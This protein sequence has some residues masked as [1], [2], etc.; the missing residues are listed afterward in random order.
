MQVA[1]RYENPDSFIEDGDIYSINN[2]HSDLSDFEISKEQEQFSLYFN[3]I[4]Y[5]DELATLLDHTI[6]QNWVYNNES[7]N[8]EKSDLEHDLILYY[9]DHSLSNRF[10]YNYDLDKIIKS[11]VSYNYDDKKKYVKLYYTFNKDTT[12]LDNTEYFTYDIGYAFNKKYSINHRQEFDLSNDTNQKR[13]YIF[14]I[15]E[16]CW[17]VSFKY[18]NSIIATNTT[19]GN[20]KRENKFY[21]ELNLKELLNFTQKY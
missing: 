2:F 6:F 11:T 21:V 20:S 8:Y 12:T 14:T 5:N 17:A 4:L 1:V 10:Y 7:Q 13:E 15:N 3:Q 9:G 18:I 16:K 19:T